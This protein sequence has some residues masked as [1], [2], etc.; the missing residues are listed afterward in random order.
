MY[1]RIIKVI[2]F[3]WWCHLVRR[4]ER[5]KLEMCTKEKSSV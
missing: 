4:C 1:Q 5:R 2:C 3:V